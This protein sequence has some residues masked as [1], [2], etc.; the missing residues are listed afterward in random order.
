[1]LYASNHVSYLDI[2]VLSGL[3]GARFITKDDV[4]GWPV[5][6]FCAQVYRTVL[7]RRASSAALGQ[8]AMMADLL[9]GG[10]GLVLFPEGTSS[11]GMRVLPFKTA[12]FGVADV[13]DNGDADLNDAGTGPLVQ[14]FSITYAR[15]AEGRLLRRGLQSLCV[16]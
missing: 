9:A 1:M 16:W 3:M 10:D 8:R 13:P 5:L 12:L 4:W 2:P 14:P 7:I 15:Y 6:D 11:D